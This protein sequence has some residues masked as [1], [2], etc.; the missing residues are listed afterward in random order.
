MTNR[1]LSDHDPAHHVQ[2]SQ[3]R[4]RALSR[5]QVSVDMFLSSAAYRDIASIGVSELSQFCTD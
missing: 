4:S 2:A 5:V 1:P 3:R